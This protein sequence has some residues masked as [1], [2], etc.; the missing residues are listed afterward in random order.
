MAHKGF[1]CGEGHVG[2]ELSHQPKDR[3]GNNAIPFPYLNVFR[4]IVN[5]K[6]SKQ[7]G[8]H[9]QIQLLKQ[10]EH[11]KY[12]DKIRFT[13]KRN[14]KCKGFDELSITM[15]RPARHCYGSPLKTII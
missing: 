14:L 5:I 15:V 12:S 9:I 11:H 6:S 2:L 1:G 4:S 7:S 13:K 8:F 3:K 10:P